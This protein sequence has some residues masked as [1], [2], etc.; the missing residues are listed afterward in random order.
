MSC[1]RKFTHAKHGKNCCDS[2]AVLHY[3]LVEGG[4]KMD[5]LTR[6]NTKQ[7]DGGSAF[8]L[9]SRTPVPLLSIKLFFKSA[10]ICVIL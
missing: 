10:I 2:L 8:S 7:G 3:T 6:M 1:Y 5:W 9:K 4:D